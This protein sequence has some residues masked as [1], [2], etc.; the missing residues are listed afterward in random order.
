MDNNVGGT[1]ASGSEVQPDGCTVR[2]FLGT[3]RTFDRSPASQ[4]NSQHHIGHKGSKCSPVFAEFGQT[5]LRYHMSAN[6]HLWRVSVSR[7]F[8]GNRTSEDGMI[9]FGQR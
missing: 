4:A 2:C 9:T 1:E 5:I 6:E 7:L 8:F 3:I